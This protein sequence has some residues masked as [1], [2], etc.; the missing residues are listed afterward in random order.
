M[1]YS[2][3]GQ[4]RWLE[5]NIFKGKRN[6]VFVEVG[7][8]N[9]IMDSNTAFF[10]FERDWTGLLIEA[11][12]RFTR[13]IITN[14][15]KS[16]VIKTAVYDTV[17]NVSFKVV[18]GTPGW[19]G[20]EK[21]FDAFHAIRVKKNLTH[22]ITVPCAPLAMLMEGFH[23][24]DYLSIDIEGAEFKILQGF[25]FQDFDI[26]I[27]GV[28]NNTGSSKVEDVLRKA[29]YEKVHKIEYDDFYAKQ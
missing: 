22:Y 12:P 2:Q 13:E 20:I 23:H 6:G 17:G 5:E 27:L 4:D 1:F 21:E 26:K 24:V 7:V 25:P 15:P 18:E 8:L 10:E 19:S 3:W 9:G 16:K 14:R 28:E 11:N 29:G